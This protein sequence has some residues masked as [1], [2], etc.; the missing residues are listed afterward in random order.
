MAV[1]EKEKTIHIMVTS[2]CKRN[3]RYCCNKQY[4]LNDIP[5]VTDDELRN[6]HTIL[7]TGGEPFAF[8][9]PCEIAAY[10]KS[11]YPNIRNVYVYGNA[12]EIVE[13]L[14]RHIGATFAD[15]DGITVSIKNDL[16][17]RVFGNIL[18]DK[19]IKNLR[20]NWLFVFNKLMPTETG[21]FK[22]IAREWQES[23]IPDNNSIFRK[24]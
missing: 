8:T 5:Y 6:A 18:N 11:R 23:F 14:Y 22:V 16:D 1:S 10:Y 12:T 7:L 9:D 17:K 19:R 21:D 20:S 2:L 15:I 24:A 13:Y 4:N 3:C